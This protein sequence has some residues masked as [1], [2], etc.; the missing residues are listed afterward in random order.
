[1]KSSKA[2]FRGCLLGGAIGDAL[3]LP[4]ENLSLEEIHDTYGETGIQD[5]IL[6]VTTKTALISDDTQL[7]AF[8]VDGLLWADNRARKKGVYAY[9][10]CL[11]YAYQKWLYTQT[12]RFADKN[13]E[14]LLQG[15]ILQWQELFARRDPGKTCLTALSGSINGKYGTIKTPI[16]SSK[17]CGAVM[18]TAPIGLYFWH[19][20]SMAFRMGCEGGAITHGHPDGYLPAGFFAW[21]IAR[22]IQG[23]TLMN[24][25]R[26]GLEELRGWEK[27]QNTADLLEKAISMAQAKHQTKGVDWNPDV[28]LAQLG[29][30]WTGDEA[31]AIAVYCTLA[32]PYDF[33]NAVRLAVNHGGDS[34]STGAI[35]GNLMGAFHGCLEIPYPWIKD[36][37]L[38]DLLVYGADMLLSA[39]KDR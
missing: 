22:I 13:Y 25:Y 17:G 26:T 33:S 3:G 38:S 19:N 31:I 27:H 34:D 15:E 39:S 4:L 2:F 24:A 8:T 5:L 37:E 9:I 10:P 29:E 16:N 7:T 23:D 21:S 32:E 28:D 36:V 6:D 14:F 1:M 18:R 11:F 12:G 20:P 30:G 35:C